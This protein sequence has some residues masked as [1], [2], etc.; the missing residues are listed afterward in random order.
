MLHESGFT[1]FAHGG[2]H[3]TSC[4]P[5]TYARPER[6][7]PTMN[8]PAVSSPV[9]TTYP[10]GPDVTCGM[11]TVQMSPVVCES[12]EVMPTPFGRRS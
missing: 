9:C 5:G 10:I 2:A 4:G 6:R 11:D 7:A 8:D 12:P 1:P 3:A